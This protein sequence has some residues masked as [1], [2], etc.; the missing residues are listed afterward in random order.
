MS[1]MTEQEKT[2]A[3]E[4]ALRNLGVPM[5]A[6]ITF[7]QLVKTWKNLNPE[8]QAKALDDMKK[9]VKGEN[10]YVLSKSQFDA[11]NK[12]LGLGSG[13][14]KGSPILQDQNKN[15]AAS[16]KVEGKAF[17]PELNSY[18]VTTNN[19]RIVSWLAERDIKPK[20][21]T[22]PKVPTRDPKAAAANDI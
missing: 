17:R 3:A 11:M 2:T 16:Y 1:I 22:A 14:D 12:E 15:Q 5:S 10:T 4:M 13:T 6:A 7:V 18:T 21:T 19:L 20:S 8:D 9:A